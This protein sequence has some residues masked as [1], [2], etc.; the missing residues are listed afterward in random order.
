MNLKFA[1]AL[2]VYSFPDR[3]PR[4]MEDILDKNNVLILMK[5][6]RSKQIIGAFTEVGFSSKPVRIPRDNPRS[7]LCNLSQEHFLFAS[8]TNKTHSVDRNYLMFG[9]W[10]IRM[11]VGEKE[12][13]SDAGK[14]GGCFM[15]ETFGG[16]EVQADPR[17]W[18]FGEEHRQ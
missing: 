8:K 4:P 1:E 2:K 13:Y 3:H 7:F 17:L 11:Q 6:E 10:E 15:R 9:N 14:K 18:L 5:L 12:L 16:R